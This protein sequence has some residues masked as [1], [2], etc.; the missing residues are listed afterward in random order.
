MKNNW[1]KPI[2]K[3]LLRKHSQLKTVDNQ[4]KNIFLI[5]HSRHRSPFNFLVNSLAALV[6]YTYSF[7]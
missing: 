6:A 7:R 2:D 5:E 1:V 4:L 3:V